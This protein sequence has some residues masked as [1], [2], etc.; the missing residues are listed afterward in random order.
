MRAT[1]EKEHAARVEQSRRE[2]QPVLD[3]LATIGVQVNSLQDLLSLSYPDERIYPILFAHLRRPYSPHLLEWIGRSFGSKPARP[4]VWNNLIAMLRAHEL[5]GG[6]L[7]GVMV[8]ISDIAK[9]RDLST[10]IE[11]ISDRALGTGRIFLVA[12]LMRSKKPEARA[13]LLQLQDDPDLTT[14]ITYRLSRVRAK[15]QP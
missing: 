3:D 6:A 10:L 12:N 1:K 9:P 8:A 2:R 5:S 14:E 4:F 11:L 7:E 15:N 13:T